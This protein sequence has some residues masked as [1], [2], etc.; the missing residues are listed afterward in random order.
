MLDSCQAP[1]HQF[2][3]FVVLIAESHP[4]SSLED[5]SDT[6]FTPCTNLSVYLPILVKNTPPNVSNVPERKLGVDMKSDPPPRSLIETSW[7]ASGAANRYALDSPWIL[8]EFGFL[9]VAVVRA[10]ICNILEFP[11]SAFRLAKVIL[12]AQVLSKPLE[13]LRMQRIGM[14][15]APLKFWA[16]SV[17][18]SWW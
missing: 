5:L 13:K 15:W 8:S 11:E 6:L 4:K 14:P 17:L 18:S 2:C 12:W 1:R 9:T 10:Q 7:K 3:G 16:N